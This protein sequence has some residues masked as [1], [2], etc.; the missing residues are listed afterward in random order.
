MRS[1]TKSDNCCTNS[2]PSS[3]QSMHTHAHAHAHTHTHTHTHAP[4]TIHTH[5]VKVLKN[6]CLHNVMLMQCN[7][8]IIIIHAF[9]N[10]PIS[11]HPCIVH[12]VSGR[13]RERGQR[14]G[15]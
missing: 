13:E 15:G 11:C 4:H 2:L 14:E 3:D 12:V 8:I 1:T 9:S 7:Y 10:C 6:V 5:H